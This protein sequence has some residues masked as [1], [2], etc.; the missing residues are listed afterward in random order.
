MDTYMYIYIIVCT[1][2]L[3]YIKFNYTNNGIRD[4][5]AFIHRCTA[6]YYFWLK[7]GC[8]PSIVAGIMGKIPFPD[9][10]APVPSPAGTSAWSVGPVSTPDPAKV[11]IWDSLNGNTM[12]IW[13][14]AAC[15]CSWNCWTSS[16]AWTASL[17][18]CFSLCLRRSND[19]FNSSIF[20][21][22]SEIT[23]SVSNLRSL[24]SNTRSYKVRSQPWG[25]TSSTSSSSSSSSP[26]SSS[27]YSSS[28]SPPP[29]ALFH[30]IFFLKIFVSMST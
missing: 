28:S 27:A 5:H 26:S 25:Q 3:K 6:I 16:S 15:F 12:A 10:P 11:Y 1:L 19:F 22:T 21:C 17:R 2:R 24:S 20:F 23:S 14:S 13:F 9:P 8:F 29:P 30:F 4:I 7:M 18:V